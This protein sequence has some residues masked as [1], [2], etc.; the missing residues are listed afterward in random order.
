MSRTITSLQSTF[1][2]T[3]KRFEDARGEW[4]EDDDI[5]GGGGSATEREGFNSRA[6]APSMRP[7]LFDARPVSRSAR[8]LQANKMPESAS[9]RMAECRVPPASIRRRSSRSVSVLAAAAASCSGWCLRPANRKS[10]EFQRSA[11]YAGG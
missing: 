1:A 5:D 8:H 3:L 6:A 2:P 7:V 11:S 4:T 10:V 9:A